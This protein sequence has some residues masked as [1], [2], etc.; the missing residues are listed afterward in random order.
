MKIVTE[1]YRRVEHLVHEAAKF[2]LVGLLG[3][4]VDVPIYNWLVYNNPLVFG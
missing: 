2:G 3:L 1:L 4:V